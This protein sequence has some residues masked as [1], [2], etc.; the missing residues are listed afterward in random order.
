MSAI[1]LVDRALALALA[2]SAFLLLALS[3]S[4]S[5]KVVWLCRPGEHPNPCAA[6][7]STT[8]MSPNLQ[9]RTVEHP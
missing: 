5:A 2:A 8:V 9:R 1:R 4:A 6:G 7:L 3:A